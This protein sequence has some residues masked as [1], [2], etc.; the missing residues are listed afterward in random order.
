MKLEIFILLLVNKR[1]DGIS[2][3][4]GVKKSAPRSMAEFELA[5]VKAFSES[6]P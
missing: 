3:V 6:Q 1:P 5:P 4:R 2:Y